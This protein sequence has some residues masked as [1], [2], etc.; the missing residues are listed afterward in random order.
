MKQRLLAWLGPS[1]VRRVV[2][3][4]LAAFALVWVTLVV[5]DYLE[6]RRATGSQEGLHRAVRAL[7]ASLDFDDAQRAAQVVLATETQYNLLRNESLPVSFGPML[8]EL[9]RPDGTR[10]Y[11]SAA[12]QGQPLPAPGGRRANGGCGGSGTAW[13]STR[14]P[15]GASG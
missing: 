2:V 10:V 11:A 7:A 6:F 15:T 12:L 4:L 8:L 13:W 5:V 1:L 9:S 3:A 14:A